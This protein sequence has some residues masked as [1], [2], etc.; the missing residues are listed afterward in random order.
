MA[1]IIPFYVPN[2]FRRKTKKWIPSEQYGRLIPFDPPQKKL[3]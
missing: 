1:K 2:S 3:A